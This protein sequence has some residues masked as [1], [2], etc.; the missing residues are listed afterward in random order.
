MTK[1]QITLMGAGTIVTLLLIFSLAFGGFNPIA[2]ANAE[3]ENFFTTL[4]SSIGEGEDDEDENEME[5]GEMEEGEEMEED[6]MDDDEGEE[7]DDD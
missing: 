4:A 1:Q 7:E 2:G 3:G 5:E 6:E